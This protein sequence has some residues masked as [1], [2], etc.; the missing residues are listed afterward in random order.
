MAK[1][2]FRASGKYLKNSSLSGPAIEK[3][4]VDT[5]FHDG[6][7]KNNLKFLPY[8][9]QEIND[10]VEAREIY[11][12]IEEGN[13]ISYNVQPGRRG[14]GISYDLNQLK[15]SPN[16]INNFKKK[17][18]E[19][20]LVCKP[21]ESKKEGFSEKNHESKYLPYTEESKS[22]EKDNLER[23][24]N[25]LTQVEKFSDQSS[26]N[27]QEIKY[28]PYFKDN[29]NGNIIGNE[30]PDNIQSGRRCRG[31]MYELSELSNSE[32]KK[33]VLPAQVESFTNTD[34]KSLIIIA[35]ILVIIL[36]LLRCVTRK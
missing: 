6:V 24:E 19:T 20:E 13:T 34:D 22:E 2:V 3:K 4:E 16:D 15:I 35:I 30:E 1:P 21:A 7:K 26:E 18:K 11:N 33:E 31:R 32:P 12:T 27:N 36:M 23:N 17:E 8:S 10:D 14:R 28:L 9:N 25:L 29:N 5:S